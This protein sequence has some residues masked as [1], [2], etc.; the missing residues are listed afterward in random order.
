MLDPTQARGQNVRL[1]HFALKKLHSNTSRDTFNQELA[2]L[3]K[4]QDNDDGKHLIKLLATFEVREKRGPKQI[5]TYYLLFPWAEGDLWKFWREHDSENQRLRRCVWM[6]EQISHLGQALMHVHNE[7]RRQLKRINDSNDEGRLELFGRHGD[8]KAD[9]ILWFDDDDDRDPRDARGGRL[10]IADFGLG[11]LNSK[12]SRS[13]VDPKMVDK[14]ATYKA[15]EFDL[16]GGKISRLSDIYS[17]G[18]TC[19][20]FVTWYLEGWHAVS[21]DFPDSRIEGDI[22]GQESDI[23]F[24]I[25]NRGAEEKAIIKPKVKDWISRLKGSRHCSNYTLQFLELIEERMLEPDSSRRIKSD[26]LVKELELL[27]DTCRRNSSF[28]KT[29]ANKLPTRSR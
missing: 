21:E 17:L 6:A 10:V 24:R 16:R 4:F 25:E 23:F 3:R 28:Y 5:S 12:Y 20:E 7:R 18:C 22:Y 13:G 1:G 11:R 14:S 15:P 27:A 19:L 2:S 29:P 9:N 8:I 26:E